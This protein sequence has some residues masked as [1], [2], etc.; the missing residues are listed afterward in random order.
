MINHYSLKDIDEKTV[1]IPDPNSGLTLLDFWVTWCNPCRSSIPKLREVKNKANKIGIE[2]IGL[3]ID[4][5]KE[6][7]KAFSKTN[8]IDWRQCVPSREGS[9]VC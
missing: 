5:D 7:V 3:S 2:V 9:G 1:D 4:T 6:Y 8:K